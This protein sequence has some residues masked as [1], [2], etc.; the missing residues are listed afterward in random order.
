MQGSSA[1]DGRMPLQAVE[2][3]RL[4]QHVAQQIREMILTGEYAPTDRLPAE[5]DL[6]RELHVSRPTVREAMIALEIAGLVEIRTGAGIFVAGEA[7]RKAATGR[8]LDAGSSPFDLL[9]ARRLVECEIAAQAAER[10]TAADLAG[11]AATLDAMAAAIE[12]ERSTQEADRAFHSGIAAVTRNGVLINIVHTLWDGMFEPLFAGL[13]AL[14]GLPRNERMTLADHRAVFAALQRRD[15][16][17][18]RSAMA[19]HL[20]HVEKILAGAADLAKFEARRRPNRLLSSTTK[21][22]GRR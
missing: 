7:R 9:A 10:A 16:T 6:A 1:K 12:T 8:G 22:G 3:H 2:T 5:R 20:N 14:T 4:Y 15:P 19:T 13:S 17:G 18:A 11:I 21:R